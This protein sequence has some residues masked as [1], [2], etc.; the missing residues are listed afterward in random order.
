LGFEARPDDIIQ[1]RTESIKGKVVEDDPEEENIWVLERG[2]K[3]KR[4]VRRKDVVK[5]L[6]H[7]GIEGA[8]Q[9]AS[10]AISKAD[11]N[12]RR[13]LFEECIQKALPALALKEAE[14][15]NNEAPGSAIAGRSLIEAYIANGDTTRAMTAAKAGLDNATDV[16]FLIAAGRAFLAAGK[17]D[18]AMQI[19]SRARKDA[20]SSSGPLLGIADALLEMGDTAGAREAYD[21]ILKQDQANYEAVLG[22]ATTYMYDGNLDKASTMF[23]QAKGLVTKPYRGSKDIRPNVGLG[24]AAYLKGDLDNAQTILWDAVSL[25]PDSQDGSYDLALVYAALGKR[26]QAYKYL[27]WANQPVENNARALIAS[28]QLMDLANA[29]AEVLKLAARAVQLAP[30]DAYVVYTA[31]YLTY[32]YGTPEQAV[33]LLGKAAELAPGAREALAGAAAIKLYAKDYTGALP[34][35]RQA[36][37]W[38]DTPDIHAGL[39]LALIGAGEAEQAEAELSKAL[40]GEGDSASRADALNGL[41]Y[42]ANHRGSREEA[43]SLFLESLTVDPTATYAK[44]ALEKLYDQEGQVVEFYGFDEAA[45]PEGIKVQGNFGVTGTVENGHLKMSGIQANADGG[46]TLALFQ[47]TRGSFN[48]AGMDITVPLGATGEWYGGAVLIAG[49]VQA[50]AART[51]EGDLAWRVKDGKTGWS[52]WTKLGEWRPA[53]KHN[54]RFSIG[55][56][57]VKGRRGAAVNIVVDGRDAAS[58][59]AMQG[60]N[61]TGVKVGVYTSAVI[62]TTVSLEADNFVIISGGSGK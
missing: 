14:R 12:A 55:S 32:R 61:A 33:P 38:W 20:G 11:M 9:E 30:N 54:I 22:L 34:L 59:P 29:P 43:K 25:K 10:D 19:F 23:A 41:G 21:E 31:G 42:L 2:A 3:I 53:T 36:L 57:I 17:V 51:P 50:V 46:E 7:V 5:I 26:E 1:T 6:P 13:K 28:A 39:G 8:Y 58:A 62:G 56:T 35:Y 45:L 47:L 60:M 24:A 18:D 44:R 52:D 48:Q 40:A 49:S 27:G 37:E 16:P 4:P 15:M